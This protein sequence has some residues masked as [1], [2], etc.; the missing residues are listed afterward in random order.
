M[1]GRN[2][3][4]VDQDFLTTDSRS[5]IVLG[6]AGMGKSTLL[7]QLTS[8]EGYVLCSARKLLISSDLKRLLGSATTLVIDALDEVPAQREGDAVDLV[9]RCLDEL[10]H[11]RFILS[12]RIT[13]WRSA[14]SI[15]A[16]ADIYESAPL[17]LHLDPLDRDDALRFLSHSIVVEEAERVLQHLEER[18][19]SG[20][21]H[22]PQTL[23]LVSKVAANGQLP[24]SKG[25]LFEEATRLLRSEHRNERSN[26]PFANLPQQAVLDSAGAGFATLIV[27][28]KEALTRETP[29]ADIDAPMADVSALPGAARL[30]DALD[31]RLF[32][33]RAT[34]RFTYGHRAIGEF[35]GARWLAEQANTPRKQRRILELLNNQSMVPASLRGIHAWLAWHSPELADRAIASDPMGVIEYGDADKLTPQQG[36]ALFE[37]LFELSNEN[38]QFRDWS[39]Y[40]AGGLVQASML[41]EVREVVQDESVEFGLRLLVLQALKGSGLIPTL[42]KELTALLF[43]KNAP[44]AL[45][46]EAGDRLVKGKSAT[47][48]PENIRKLVDDESE[49][50]VRLAS[51]LM[52][53][54]GYSDFSDELVLD[55]IKANLVRADNT[56]GVFFSLERNF[57]DDRLDG[58]L[59]GVS[60]LA[61]SIGSPDGDRSKERIIDLAFALIA[62]R[63]EYRVPDAEQLWSWLHLFD[64][65]R[66]VQREPRRMIS[67][68]LEAN[69]QL[70]RALQAHVLLRLESE[71]NIWQRY[72][73]ALKS[74]PALNPTDKDVIWLLDQIEIGDPRWRELVELSRHGPENGAVVRSAAERFATDDHKD[75]EWLEELANPRIPDW[76]VEQERKQRERAAQQVT[77]WE[78]HRA[79]FVSRIDDLRTGDYGL[80]VNPAKAYLKLFHD[81][82][83]APA[84]GPARIEEWLGTD[85][86]DAALAGFEAHLTRQP[87]T[88]TAKQIADSSAEGKHWDAAY[89]IVAALAERVRTKREFDDLDEER[90]MAGYIEL[91]QS[92]INDH[93]GLGDL[94][95][96]LATE[97]RKREQWETTLRL[98]F[99]PQLAT[100]SEHIAGLYSVLRNENDAALVDRLGA[101][102]LLNFPQMSVLA[103]MEIVDRL[104][105]SATGNKSLIAL[106]TNRVA[107]NNADERRDLWDAVGIIL[108]FDATRARIE[109]D[110]SVS[111]NLFWSLRSRLGGGMNTQ[112]TASLN[113]DQ[114]FWVI[115]TFR[116]LFPYTAHPTGSTIGDTNDWNATEYLKVLINRL[117]GETSADATAA[118][119]ALR[120]AHFD[121]Y[122]YHLRVALAEQKRK[123]AEE[124][125]VTPDIATFAAAVADHSPTTAPQL[126]AVMLE[127]LKMVQAQITGDPRDWYKDFFLENGDPK[128]EEDCRDTILKIFGNLPFG[129]QASPEG[130]LAD[131]KRCDI[132]CTLPGIMVPIE[133]KGQW[134]KDLW[135]AAD[136]QLD[137]L[138]TN[139]FRA[140]RGIYLVLWF[141]PSVGKKLKQPP[142]DI[143]TPVSAEHLQT[144]LAEQS[145]TTREGRTNVVVLDLTRPT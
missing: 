109:A 67:E 7:S 99:E 118:L 41:A 30:G 12:C 110:G 42:H 96:R 64:S 56:V 49:N 90:L 50:S 69:D 3:A 111:R 94:D 40:R 130:H 142:S 58:L 97:L 144:A 1:D 28:G 104:L 140:E 73:L 71:K 114:L 13:D 34:D 6:E 132:E 103:E 134:H 25:Q 57:P 137:L 124:N 121:G 85:L 72:I 139:D 145:A 52:S 76:Q 91:R 16:I 88:P 36:R 19:L 79:N 108:D 119:V 45:R 101:E 122:T 53:E 61:G 93:A 18:G 68:K 2:R 135:T 35:L 17:E 78:R 77:D 89:I 54:V 87:P 95:Q 65:N 11:P 9:L 74:A 113:V 51:E 133:V 8:V 62:K 55:M 128:G 136:R 123:R 31:S 120:N 98:S 29:P 66:G 48:W 63:L 129:I 46:S 138:Y 5:I 15:Q 80:I 102:W 33:A 14:T 131:D 22:N 84:D 43:D 100:A 82:G 4:G 105:S 141:G 44:F 126:E 32:E 20:L 39:E 59:D 106:L 37:A 125:W 92:S 23:E 83:D 10:E 47:D 70:R 24:D 116:P 107:A 60:T 115:Q 81:L 127:E 21:W 27:A 117:G 143:D 75:L 112:P 86:K 26:A 38:P